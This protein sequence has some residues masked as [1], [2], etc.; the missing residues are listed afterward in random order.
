MRARPTAS[1][2]AVATTL[3]VLLLLVPVPQTSRDATADA[4]S[5]PVGLATPTAGAILQ[6]DPPTWQMAAG[7]STSLFATWLGPAPGCTLSDLWYHWTLS[8]ALNSGQLN[9]TSGVEVT[10]V[11]DGAEPGATV[12]T[13]EGAALLQCPNADE[14]LVENATAT[15]TVLA[16]IDLS[17]FTLYPAPLAPGQNATLSASI[18][19]GVPPY[20]VE[21][22]WGDGTTSTT[23]LMVAGR[24]AASHA[25][26]QVGE[27]AP[28]LTVT[29]S[30]GLIAHAT[31]P[32]TADVNSGTA[33]SISADRPITDVDVPVVWNATVERD[34]LSLF[35]DPE[36]NGLPP[37]PPELPN[38]TVGTCTFS[39]PGRAIISADIVPV[40]GPDDA[41]ASTTV[42]VVS[43][44][45][46]SVTPPTA[47]GEVGLSSYLEVDVAGGVPPLNLTC[48]GPDLV[49][50]P[51]VELPGDGT[52]LVPVDPSEAGEIDYTL[53]V[54]DSEDLDSPPVL[55]TLLVEPSLNVSFQE[56]GNLNAT[57]VN[58][59]L[60]GSVTS[61]VGPF[62]WA[63][64]PSVPGAGAPSAAGVLGGPGNVG[65]SAWYR[66][67]GSVRVRALV[68]DSAGD[69]LE[70]AWEMP[71]IPP[72]ELS[73]SSLSNRTGSLGTVAL[74]VDIAGGLPPFNLT[75]QSPNGTLGGLS[76]AA[77]GTVVWQ[78][79]TSARGSLPVTVVVRDSAGDDGWANATVS[80]P[81]LP[82]TVV[83]GSA[84]PIPWVVAS[85]ALLAGVGS[86][87]AFWARRRRRPAVVAAP[88]DPTPVLRAILSP[89][90]GA[91]RTT[92]ELLAEQ[93]G[94]P[95]GTARSALDRLIAEGVVRSEIDPD[96]I[97]VL[98]WVREAAP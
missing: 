17:D 19:G 88:A 41:Y 34:P 8:S 39:V 97:E 53:Q 35:I 24:L 71:A 29:D 18:S 93:E 98:S 89:A 20:T 70:H 4:Y 47:P 16:N 90:D 9:A 81:T 92:V 87:A 50:S 85:L 74:A 60:S 56:S 58:L 36:C 91:E 59:S 37:F 61:G 63:I 13:V 79:T 96:G 31:D 40:V 23:G 3:G 45:T 72:L 69:L 6:V 80:I 54:E 30:D 14:P 67:E 7:G 51:H 1:A 65:W 38:A 77:D 75:A 12:I 10:F 28:S 64:V 5:R 21:I 25:F 86:I 66:V 62:V 43:P 78:L 32:T 94:V 76:V 83:V 15:V 42:S 73:V 11:G 22:D 82:S 33:V 27:Y 44:P 2:V 52:V 84:A 48:S 57:G 46:V 95:L 68:A 49:D 55:A 26:A